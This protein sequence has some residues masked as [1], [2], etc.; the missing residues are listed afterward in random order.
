MRAGSSAALVALVMTTVGV[1]AA[2]QPDRSQAERLAQRA[3]E[4]LKALHDEADRLATQERSLL[5]DLRRLEVEREI[6]TTELQQAREVVR[7][8]EDS[9]AVLDGQTKALTDETNAALPDLQSRLVTLYKLG[10]G[11]Y[12]RLLLSASDLRQL[13]QAVRLVSAVAEQDRQRL[14]QQQRRLSELTAAREQARERQVEVTRLEEAA[15]KAQIAADQAIA[16][17]NA[18][19]RDIDTR[20]DLNSQYAA[21]LMAAQQRLQTS[22]TDIAAPPAVALPLLPFK[23]A[24]DWPVEG[25]VRHRF[26]ETAAGR[27]P[28]RGIEVET[29]AG[30]TVRAVHEGS[31]AYADAFTGYG[32]LV[33]V[34]HGN[35]TFSLYGNLSGISVEQG[36]HVERGTAVGDV[37]ST[38]S[39]APSFYF[40]L[41]VDGRPVDPLQW[42][43]KR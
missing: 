1:L 37:G 39:E 2:Q 25:T 13:G 40:E 14:L 24:L 4:R 21:E 30:A 9:L 27:P 3:T 32:R 38:A 17:R 11:R 42:L 7:D 19:I 5:G 22:L 23:G 26:G 34:D 6:R 35:Q 29:T 16:A 43:A 33:I 10:R 12:A 20:R 18:L 15:Q 36:R 8:A 28:L 41:R 31:V